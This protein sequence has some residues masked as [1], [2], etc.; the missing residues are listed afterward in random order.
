DR[1]RAEFN[2]RKARRLAD[3]TAEGK[4]LKEN[5][6]TLKNKR[7]QLEDERNALSLQVEDLEAEYVELQKELDAFKA[8]MPD[9]LSDPEYARLAADKASVEQTIQALQDDVSAQLAAVAAELK[10][11]DEQIAS[12]EAALARFE[13]HERGLKRIEELKAERS[14]EH[15]SELQSRENLVCR[16]LLEKKKKDIT[17]SD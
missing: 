2:E 6:E 9:P 17:P 11:V 14:E 13:A 7:N 1:R 15:T 3:I 12:V 5:V 10:S 4:R 16:L 8:A